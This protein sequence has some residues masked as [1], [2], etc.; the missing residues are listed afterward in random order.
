MICIAAIIEENVSFDVSKVKKD[1]CC[2]RNLLLITAGQVTNA[3]T[4]MVG[5]Q[6]CISP[7]FQAQ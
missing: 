6:M 1:T 2:L 3:K 7:T 5:T 4:S